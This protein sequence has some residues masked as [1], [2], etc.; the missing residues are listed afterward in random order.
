VL[1]TKERTPTLFPSVIF[2]FG[3]PVESIKKLGGASKDG[4]AHTSLSN[5]QFLTNMV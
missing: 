5:V 3:L 4:F 1:Q 2:T